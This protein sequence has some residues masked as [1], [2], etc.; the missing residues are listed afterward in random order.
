MT[1]LASE[2]SPDG[3]NLFHSFQQ[4]GLDPNQIANFITPPRY[5]NILGRVGGDP[6]IING[7]IRRHRRQLQP[8]FN[9]PH[10]HHLWC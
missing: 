6:S 7:L 8:I 2:A 4:F 5:Q 1:S 9:Q 10:W 3:A